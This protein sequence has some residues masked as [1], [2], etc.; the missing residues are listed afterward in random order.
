MNVKGGGGSP[1]LPASQGAEVRGV[2]SRRR[3]GADGRDH[4]Q[5]L[6]SAAHRILVSHTPLP[7]LLGHKALA[8]DRPRLLELRGWGMSDKLAR[9]TSAFVVCPMGWRGAG[10]HGAA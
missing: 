5:I 2:E 7:R 6:R 4:A 8:A 3:V 10:G 1:T 9:G